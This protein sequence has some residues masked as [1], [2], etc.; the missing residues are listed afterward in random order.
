MYL[1]RYDA[2]DL[3]RLSFLIVPFALCFVIR[4]FVKNI[5]LALPLHL[6]FPVVAVI[7][8][9]GVFLQAVWLG[10]MIL[11]ALISLGHYFKRGVAVGAGFVFLCAAI[12]IVLSVWAASGFHWPLVAL[13]TVL[14]VI[15]TI[16]CIVLL[17]M[18][19]MDIS[20]DAMQLSSAQPVRRIISFNYK[21]VAG[22]AAG[23]LIL[24]LIVFFLVTAPLFGFIAGL[25]SESQERDRD[26]SP[27]ETAVTESDFDYQQSREWDFGLSPYRSDEEITNVGP[28]LNILIAVAAACGVY[29][30]YK[31][32]TAFFGWL[33]RRKFYSSDFN[34][35]NAQDEREFILPRRKKEKP[36]PRS[37]KEHPIRRLF[38]ETITRHIKAGVTINPSDTPAD[39]TKRIQ[40]EDLSVLS[41]RYANIRYTTEVNS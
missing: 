37:Q 23:I 22:L 28:L 2:M 15:S 1:Y 17:H 12:F 13:Y 30:L 10:A 33:N 7:F 24:T 20:L 11:V 31:V 40:T 25:F 34:D 21:L 9:S 38:R 8:V 18:V 41:E 35:T 26:D 39:M 5:W 14:L 32:F 29:I 6:I 4:W 3:L 16:G 27:V 19:Q 36:A